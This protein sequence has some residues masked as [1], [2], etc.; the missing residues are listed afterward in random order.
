VR[1]SVICAEGRTVVATR[2]VTVEF[3]FAGGC[4]HCAKA[5]EALRDA[6]ESTPQVEWNEIDIGKNPHR[7]VDIGVIST[8]AVAIDGSLVFKSAPT[9]SDLRTAIKARIGRG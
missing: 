3:F 1:I 9:P 7:A 4:S 2:T 5:R 6:A 8:P